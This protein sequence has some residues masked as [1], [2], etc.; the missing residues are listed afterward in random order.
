MDI[1]IIDGN[2]N[3]CETGETGEIVLESRF[4][5]PGYQN[6]EEENCARFATGD[7]GIVTY[8]SGNRFF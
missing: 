5:S 7:D 4:I 6:R 3:G 1:G 8:R 2:G